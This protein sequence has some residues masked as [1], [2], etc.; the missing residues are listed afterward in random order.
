MATYV[1][2]ARP[3]IAPDGRTIASVRLPQNGDLHVFTVATG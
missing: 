2:A 1:F 3:F